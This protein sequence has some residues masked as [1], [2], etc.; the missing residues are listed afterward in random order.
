MSN[1]PAPTPDPGKYAPKP[2]DAV[3][4]AAA[5]AEE[6]QRQSIGEQPANGGEGQ[7]DPAPEAQPA[8]PQQQEGQRYYT[9]NDIRAMQGRYEREREANQSLSERINGLESLLAG[10]TTEPR[11]VTPGV[12]AERLITSELEN[13]YGKDFLDVVGK[14]AKDEMSFDLNKLRAELEQVKTGMNVVGTTLVRTSED[15]MYD[16]LDGEIGSQWED[17]NNHQSFH[18]WL[19][20]IDPYSGRRRRDMLTDA[21]SRHDGPR[22]VTFFKGFLAEAA[23]T[24]PQPAQGAPY[25]TPSQANGKVPLERFAAPGRA[26]PAAPQRPV[27]KPTYSRSFIAQFYRDKAAGRWAGRDADAAAIDADIIAAGREGR[28]V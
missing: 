24:D 1:G 5:R 14:K 8:S 10:V 18:N 25:Q 26:G 6:L 21:F 12:S 16:M 4:Q 11:E 19:G 7:H 23:A 27:D 3:T 15:R 2:P 20:E 28:V 9:E 22:V 17:I 13:E